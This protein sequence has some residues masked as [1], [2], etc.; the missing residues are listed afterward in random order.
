MSEIILHHYPASPFAQKVRSALGIKGLSWRSVKIPMVMPKPDLMP[1]TGGYRKT[2]VMQIGADIYCDTQCILRELERR[3]P[4]PSL[5]TGTTEG[6]AMAMSHWSDKAL[7][8]AVVVLNFGAIGEHLPEEFIKDR[9]E[10]GGAPFDVSRMKAAAPLMLD[11]LRAFLDWTES[12]IGDGPFIMGDAAGMADLNA[13]HVLWFLRKQH[14]GAGPILEPYA[15]TSA[16]LERMDTIGHGTM[17][18]M[19]AAD[20]LDVARDATSTTEAAE[21]PGDPSGRKPGDRL[22]VMPDDTGRVPVTGEL[23]SSSA[24]H[25]AIRRSEER[26]GEV[27]VHFPRAGFRVLPARD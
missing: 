21:D 13:F 25:V 6:Q 4:T 18:P 26:V 23:V 24:H 12:M 9:S 14:P 2:P 20:A 16:W 17:A 22:T 19:D 1:L 8:S 10:M 11:Q 15:K 3:Y 27:V 7:F 5:F